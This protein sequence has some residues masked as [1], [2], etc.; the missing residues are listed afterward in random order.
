[1]NYLKRSIL[2]I[3]CFMLTMGTLGACTKEEQSALERNNET[4][5]SVPG[6]MQGQINPFFAQAEGDLQVLSVMTERFLS[7]NGVATHEAS[8]DSNGF[9][10]VTV[11]INKGILCFQK[12]ELWAEDLRYAIHFV[13][14]P[15]YDGPLTG[16]S[17]SSIVGLQ[18]FQKGETTELAGV[19]RVDKYTCQ[20]TFSDPDED[21]L[22]LLDLPAV[23]TANYGD[24]TYGKCSYTDLDAKYA[25]VIG[26]GPYQVDRLLP[27]DGKLWNLIP[28]E[29]YHLA[30]A[31]MRDV[32]IRY[33]SSEDVGL[34]MQ[35][36]QLTAGF[37]YDHQSAK[38]QAEKY[39][40]VAVLLAD[41]A[42]LCQKNA[43]FISKLKEDMSINQA[44][45]AVVTA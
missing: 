17:E 37:L 7:S 26:T 3:V 27:S 21:Y 23:H 5:F 20:V 4:A 13:C 18:E 31:K 24:Y 6:N 43:E 9:L 22:T 14:D 29:N 12:S 25:K 35:L 19:V 34:N 15:S 2:L 38:E 42:L 16:L 41:G 44:L 33:V 28:N 11:T 32:T 45:V 8:V 1:M 30:E 39:G 10:T 40:Y 36:G